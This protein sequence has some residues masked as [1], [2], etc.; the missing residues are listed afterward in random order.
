M[1]HGIGWTPENVSKFLLNRGAYNAQFMDSG[2]STQ[3]WY[4]TTKG[5][6]IVYGVGKE[7]VNI[8]IP[9]CVVLVEEK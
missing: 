3:M 4:K 2:R 5:S 6:E 9:N 8:T 7:N 1:N